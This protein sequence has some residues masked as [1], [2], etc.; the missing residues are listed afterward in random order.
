M[1]L[2]GDQDEQAL[3]NTSKIS[4]PDGG[5]MIRAGSEAIY[6]S[7]LENGKAT[8]YILEARSGHEVAWLGMGKHINLLEVFIE[9]T[10]AGEDFQ[11]KIEFF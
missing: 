4:M 6:Q 5:F 8:F 7:R 1:L 2:H 10:L 9:W 11:G 3:N